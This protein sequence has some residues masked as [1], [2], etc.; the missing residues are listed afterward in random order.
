MEIK[1]GKCKEEYRTV[2]SRSL[3]AAKKTLE[4]GTLKVQLD[5][6]DLKIVNPNQ[7]QIG[8]TSKACVIHLIKLTL[9]KPGS[10]ISGQFKVCFF[11]FFKV[12]ISHT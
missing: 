12:K 7:R 9:K 4:L 6:E 8:T 3:N 1:I 11:F 10:S 5:M 2:E